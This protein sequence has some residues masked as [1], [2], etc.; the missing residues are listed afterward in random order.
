MQATE[1]PATSVYECP[2]VT[3]TKCHK[4][5]GLD[6]QKRIPSRLWRPRVWDRAA[7]RAGAG[8]PASPSIPWLLS[9]ALCLGLWGPWPFPRAATPPSASLWGHTRQ[10]VGP[11]WR[12]WGR[13]SCPL[14]ALNLITLSVSLHPQVSGVRTQLGGPGR[15]GARCQLRSPRKPPAGARVHSNPDPPPTSSPFC[16]SEKAPHDLLPSPAETRLA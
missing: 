1:P 10:H 3:A 12:S 8:P 14:R 4:L 2:G 7:G 15:G 5:G 16:R 11:T 6:Q 9:A 13:A